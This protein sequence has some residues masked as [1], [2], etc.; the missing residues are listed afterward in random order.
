MSIEILPEVENRLTDEA[1]KLGISVDALPSVSSTNE[2]RSRASTD[3]S[4]NCR[5][6]ISER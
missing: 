3:P 6:G 1:R 5:S 4:L 2:R